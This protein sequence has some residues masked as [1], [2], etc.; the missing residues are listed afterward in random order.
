MPLPKRKPDSGTNTCLSPSANLILAPSET[1]PTRRPRDPH[2]VTATTTRWQ[3]SNPQ[4]TFSLVR[5]STFSADLLYPVAVGAG[6][7]HACEIAKD[8]LYPDGTGGLDG[9]DLMRVQ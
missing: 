1:K 9:F 5:I 2:H 8:L 7:E 4:T 6:S 3:S